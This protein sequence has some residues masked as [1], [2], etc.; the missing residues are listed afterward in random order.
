[1]VGTAVPLRAGRT[2]RPPARPT[3]LQMLSRGKGTKACPTAPD[4]SI[5][6]QRRTGMP[7]IATA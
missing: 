7:V 5:G 2:T 1:M 3:I 4:A 6:R